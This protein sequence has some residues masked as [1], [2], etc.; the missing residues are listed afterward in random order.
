MN[1]VKNIVVFDGY[2]FIIVQLKL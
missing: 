1:S 2:Y